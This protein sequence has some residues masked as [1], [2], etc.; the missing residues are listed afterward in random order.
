LRWQRIAEE[1]EQT[2]QKFGAGALGARRTELG[3][4]PAVVEVASDAFVERE[5]ITVILSDKG[6]I[7]AVKGH[8]GDEAELRF[9]EGDRLKRLLHCQT[10]DRLTLFGTNGRAYTLKAGELPRGRGDGQP[11][12]LLADL[13]NED[14]VATLFI[15]VEGTK[16]LVASSTGRGFIVPSEEL[17]AEKR[18]GKQV[19]NL[20]PGEE[21]ALCVAA[22]GDH[23]AIVGSNRKLLIFPLDQV[24]EMARGGGVI[25]QRYRDGGL[26]DA[27]VFRLADGLTWRLGEKTRTE[28][29]LRDW[30]GERAQAGRLPP[31]GFPRSGRFA[32]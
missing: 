32:G 20:K 6:W 30:I 7:R 24:P 28:T 2:R 27:K 1:L 17:A 22:D 13:T 14:D 10:T 12:R 16:Y 29:N 31:N 5:P 26:A 18:T 9:K 3:V 19:L 15:P 4:P 23:V 8:V 25:L 21:A 11:V